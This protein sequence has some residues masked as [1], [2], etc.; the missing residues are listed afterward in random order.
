[1]SGNSTIAVKYIDETSL[2]IRVRLESEP[3][4]SNHTIPNER[5]QQR[6]QT[7]NDRTNTNQNDGLLSK[8]P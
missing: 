3:N 5:I 7:Q 1:M 4:F 6:Q 2:F 8:S